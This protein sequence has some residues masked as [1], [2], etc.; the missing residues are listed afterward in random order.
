MIIRLYSKKKS[1]ASRFAAALVAGAI[2]VSCSRAQNEAPKRQTQQQPPGSKY[3][4]RI[5]AEEVVLNCTVIDSRGQMVNGLD[6]D[7]FRVWDDKRAEK[8]ISVQ[9]TDSP[10]S[11][12]LL[13]DNSGSMRPKRTAVTEAALDLVRASNPEDQTFVVNFSDQAYLDQNFTADFARLRASLSHPS[14]IGGTAIYDTVMM[15]SK[16]LEADATRPRKVLVVVTDGEDNASKASL[17]DAI[18]QVQSLQ[19]PVIYSIGLL[20]DA[21]T[22]E[23]VRQA[24]HDLQALSNET[25]GIA[26]FPKSTGDIDRVAGEVALAIRKQYTLAYRASHGSGANSY[27]TV[28]VEASAPGHAKLVVHTRPGYLESGRQPAA[29]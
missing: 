18:R 6:K 19:G 25:G 7:D 16:K 20:F 29:H 15:A 3:T 5:N 13:V 27:H 8:L 23:H 26:F 11:I 14:M 21:E 2:L 28:K 1:A 12:G 10:V 4:F 22:G 9:Q 24:R 17:N